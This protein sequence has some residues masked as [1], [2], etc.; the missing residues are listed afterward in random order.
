MQPEWNIFEFKIVLQNL[1]KLYL[2]MVEQ[3]FSQGTIVR[4]ATPCSAVG[5]HRR[6]WTESFLQLQEADFAGHLS[7]LLFDWIWTQ[8][9][10][11]ETSVNLCW[12][13]LR[14]MQEYSNFYIWI[15]CKFVVP[16]YLTC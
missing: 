9:H 6:F 14:Y 16:Q 2:I 5:V 10:S 13:T 4:D 8:V 12:I 11:S 15:D 7:G 1:G 3:R